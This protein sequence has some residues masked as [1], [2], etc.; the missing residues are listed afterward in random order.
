MLQ[1]VTCCERDNYGSTVSF[2][3]NI[4][5]K[6]D[7]LPNRIFYS[8]NLD[9]RNFINKNVILILRGKLNG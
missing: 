5:E 6:V 7:R 8:F 9:T 4:I 1:S 2:I 3:R